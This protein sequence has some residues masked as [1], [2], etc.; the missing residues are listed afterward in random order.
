M[1]YYNGKDF[2]MKKTTGELLE[3]M[4]SSHSYAEYL[5]G[6]REDIGR[7]CMKIDRALNALLADKG[8][9]KATVIARSG[10]ENHYA[11][12]I[13]SGLK[14]PTRDKVLML[15]VGFGLSVE[16]IQQL[17]RITGYAQLDSKG[18]RDNAILFGFTKRL[19]ILDINELLFELRLELLQ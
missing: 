2:D 5:A 13:F 4:K 16:E 15:G 7:E 8:L 11:Y 14:T 9:G 17:L 12:Q 6:C 1:I 10:V 3:L 19:S 18:E